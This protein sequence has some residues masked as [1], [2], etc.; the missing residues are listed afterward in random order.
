MFTVDVH[1]SS[2][3]VWQ[4]KCTSV[5]LFWRAYHRASITDTNADYIGWPAKDDD[6][7]THA[8]SKMES[9]FTEEYLNTGPLIGKARNVVML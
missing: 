7:S 2:L 1:A 4:T 5:K 8:L 9:L 6:A 3:S